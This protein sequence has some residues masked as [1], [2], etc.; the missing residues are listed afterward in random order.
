M[1]T[2]I[3]LRKRFRR[4]LGLLII[5]IFNLCLFEF[6]ITGIIKDLVSMHGLRIIACLVVLFVLF[7]ILHQ[8]LVAYRCTLEVMNWEN[9]LE[10]TL[11]KINL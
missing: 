9:E 6:M 10:A 5:A 11:N 2:R 1:A 8:F 4:F 7:Y 3:T